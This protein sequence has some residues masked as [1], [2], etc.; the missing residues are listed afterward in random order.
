MV[1]NFFGKEVNLN[2]NDKFK[3]GKILI[4]NYDMNGV[5]NILKPYECFAVLV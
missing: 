1:C 5:S 4:S 3:K 2:I